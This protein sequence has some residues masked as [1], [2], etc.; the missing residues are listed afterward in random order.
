MTSKMALL[1]VL[2]TWTL[3][4]PATSRALDQ[5]SWESELNAWR[6]KRAGSLQA[7]DGW[8]SLI[9]LGWLKEG[10]NSF[11]SEAD[12]RIQINGKAPAHVGIVRFEKASLRLL[13][14][15]GGF[16]KDL[17]VD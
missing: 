9:G 11:G 17:L 14:P 3:V 1:V 7:P 16:P 8:L 6:E 4:L 13:P 2:V 15:P 5:S 12:N 10:D